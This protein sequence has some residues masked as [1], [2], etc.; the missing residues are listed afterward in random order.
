MK[1]MIEVEAEFCDICLSGKDVFYRCLKCGK[2]ACFNCNKAGKLV[3]Y[4]D[5]RGTDGPGYCIDCDRALC[6]NPDPLFV[7]LNNMER[8][9]RQYTD[10]HTK[11]R[12]LVDEIAA[13]LPQGYR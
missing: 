4:K 1:K 2:S 5:G 13:L 12:A 9:L 11:E 3:H 10:L 6:A 8:L 7:A